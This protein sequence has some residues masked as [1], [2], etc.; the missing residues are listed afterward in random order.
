MFGFKTLLCICT[1]LNTLTHNF[2]HSLTDFSD[3]L[4]LCHFLSYLDVILLCLAPAT[5]IAKSK[6]VC[7]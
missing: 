2:H 6:K 4:L 5:Q 1:T 3:E 7:S